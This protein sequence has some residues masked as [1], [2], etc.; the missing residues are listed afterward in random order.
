M[1]EHLW[2]SGQNWANR[3]SWSICWW[4]SVHAEG[5]LYTAVAPDE[6][7]ILLHPPLPLVGVSIV[8]EGERQ[9]NDSFV[10]GYSS[11]FISEAMAFFSEPSLRTLD[12]R[13]GQARAGAGS[14]KR[15][16]QTPT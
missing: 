14:C 8:T 15:S 12:C 4:S 2:R 13:R 7:V 3:L 6:T 5:G 1:L 9:Q 16:R 11:P 10:R